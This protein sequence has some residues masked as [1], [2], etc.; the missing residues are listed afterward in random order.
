MIRAI[1]VLTFLA[2]LAFVLAAPARAATGAP[3]MTTTGSTNPPIGHFEF[4]KRYPAE[5]NQVSRSG[6]PMHLTPERW[7][8]MLGVNHSINSTV[9]PVTDM[10]EYGVQ[11]YWAYPKAA[12][13]CEDYV[14]AKRRMLMDD[15]FPASDLL[16]TVVLQPN[17]DGHAVLTVHTDRG[18]FVLDNMR[19]EIALWSETEY[20]YVK[21]QSPLN[22]GRWDKI[23]DDR[24]ALVGSVR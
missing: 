7:K 1:H 12:G 10:D 21:R 14:L 16:I 6:E 17:G 8:A 24:P 5:C 20:T 9:E 22:S 2:G 3:F 23:S 19:N 15:G 4:C 13:D 11:E 18:D